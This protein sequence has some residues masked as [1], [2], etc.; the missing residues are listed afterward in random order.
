MTYD[1][2]PV[3]DGFLHQVRDLAH[4]EGAL[5]ILDEMRSGFRIALGGAQEQGHGKVVN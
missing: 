3:A 2:E 5:F 4:R 1:V